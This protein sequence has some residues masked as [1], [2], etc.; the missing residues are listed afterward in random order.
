MTA[1][2]APPPVAYIGARLRAARLD[3]GMTQADLAKAAS[4]S[5]PQIANIEAGVTDTPLR[6][7]AAIVSALKA[8]ASAL[9]REPVCRQCGDQPPAGFTC[10]ACKASEPPADTEGAEK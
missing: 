5:R 8:D 2:S 6:V 9:L 3:A 1:R 10:N 7:F 4:V